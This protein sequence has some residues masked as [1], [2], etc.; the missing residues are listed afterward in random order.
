MKRLTGQSIIAKTLFLMLGLCILCHSSLPLFPA[1]SRILYFLN[2]PG[3]TAETV[4]ADFPGW[5][6]ADT[7]RYRIP[8]LGSADYLIKSPPENLQGMRLAKDIENPVASFSKPIG[9]E[10]KSLFKF[11]RKKQ[12]FYQWQ[13]SLC[14][15]E[16]SPFMNF[17]FK[18]VTISGISQRDEKL[19]VTFQFQRVVWNYIPLNQKKET[20]QKESK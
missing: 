13:V 2:V 15:P 12:L 1:Q 10:D 19:Y 16:G 8:G 20:N 9:K 14:S 11:L 5:I 7:F 17:L 3:A 18:G 4:L 6:K